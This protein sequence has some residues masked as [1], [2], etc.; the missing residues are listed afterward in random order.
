[1]GSAQRP[2]HSTGKSAT[3]ERFVE[4]LTDF[5]FNRNT[6]DDNVPRI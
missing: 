2:Y 6:F 5:L 3:A 4:T 1:M